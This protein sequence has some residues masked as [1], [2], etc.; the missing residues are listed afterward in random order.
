MPNIVNEIDILWFWLLGNKQYAFHKPFF[1][2]TRR[3]PIRVKVEI[4]TLYNPSE[5]PF[6]ENLRF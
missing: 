3:V 4:V 6:T 1:I 2:N 5:V